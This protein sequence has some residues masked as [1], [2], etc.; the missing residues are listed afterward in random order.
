MDQAGEVT[1][2]KE[3]DRTLLRGGRLSPPDLLTDWTQG[4]RKEEPKMVPTVLASASGA[5]G[6]SCSGLKESMFPRFTSRLLT[7]LLSSHIPFPASAS[8][9]AA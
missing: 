3:S 6:N 8:F 5:T 7:L 1:R 2:V 9:S 4:V